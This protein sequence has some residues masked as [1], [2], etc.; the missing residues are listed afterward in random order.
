MRARVLSDLPVFIEK[1][2]GE[3]ATN[4]NQVIIPAEIGCNSGDRL[5]MANDPLSLTLGMICSAKH[6]DGGPEIDHDLSRSIAGDATS[7][8]PSG[9]HLGGIAKQGHPNTAF[10]SMEEWRQLGI[11]WVKIV[12]ERIH[13]FDTSRKERR[14]GVCS[15][16]D[17]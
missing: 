11:I 8:A 7:S 6:A 1:Q 5:E 10:G 2:A 9:S 17:H 4:P 3:R 16:Q 14:I 15:A 13:C 12:S